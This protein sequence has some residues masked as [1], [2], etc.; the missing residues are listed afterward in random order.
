[1]CFGCAHSSALESGEI[2]PN[3]TYDD[4]ME[5]YFWKNARKIPKGKTFG[6]W[7]NEMREKKIKD[8]K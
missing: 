6:E 7:L 3:T 8:K 5:N 2:P 4:Y 1:M